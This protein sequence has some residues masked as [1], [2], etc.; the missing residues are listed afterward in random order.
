MPVKSSDSSPAAPAVAE[1]AQYGQ[2]VRL[3]A[4]GGASSVEAVTTSA[5]VE[6]PELMT[7]DPA[8]LNPILSRDGPSPAGPSAFFTQDETANITA[9]LNS[10][11]KT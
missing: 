4:A 3:G 10:V 9:A 7:E 11:L 1:Q 5:F 6:T 2:V 8:R